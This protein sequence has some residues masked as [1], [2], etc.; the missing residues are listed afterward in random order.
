[1]SFRQVVDWG[2]YAEQHGYGYFFRSDHLQPT[3]GDLKRDSPECWI[4][5]GALAAKTV[6]IKFGPMV[7]PVGFRNPTLL[8][9]MACNLHSY[10]NGRLLLGVGAGWYEKEYLAKGYEF[11][12]V[13]VRREQLVEALKIIKP[14]VEGEQVAFRGNYYA[15]NT[16]CYP[17]GKVHLIL[18]GWSKSIREATVE[19]ADEW[20]LF[21]GA[22]EDFKELKQQIAQTGRRVVISRTG[23][24][25]IAKNRAQLRRQLRSKAKLLKVDWNLP[26]TIDELNKQEVLCGDVNEFACQLSEL[27]KAGV[28]RFYFD[29]FDPDD[30]Q[31][32]N[33]L[34]RALSN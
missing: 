14:L 2:V 18:G 10:C 30:T 7:S 13:D 34:T 24:F 32:V 26:A 12:E 27:K 31:M 6:R 29:I 19:Y 1:M 21:N 17:K 22:P 33:L 4:T 16:T 11:P 9:Q 5:L 23:P 3:N 28:D 15:A 25:F 20:N 8:A